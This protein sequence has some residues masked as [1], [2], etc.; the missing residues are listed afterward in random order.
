MGYKEVY[1]EANESVCERYE[2][3]MERIQEISTTPDVENKYCHFFAVHHRYCCL[4][5]RF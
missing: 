5:K 3:V 1:Q 2:L 4:P